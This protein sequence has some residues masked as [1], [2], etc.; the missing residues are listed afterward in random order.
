LTSVIQEKLV[1]DVTS[2]S[3]ISIYRVP[4]SQRCYQSSL[5]ASVA[6]GTSEVGSRTIRQRKKC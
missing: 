3:S 6:E 2:I 4:S 1:G 5:G